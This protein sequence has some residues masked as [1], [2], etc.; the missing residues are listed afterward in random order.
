MSKLLISS[1]TGECTHFSIDREVTTVGRHSNNDLCLPHLSVSNSHALIFPGKDGLIL[2]DLQST[3]GTKVNG[4]PI[5]EQLLVHLDDI[6][7]G[8]YKISYSETTTAPADTTAPAQVSGTETSAKGVNLKDPQSTNGIKVHGEPKQEQVVV[9]LD[10]STIG[11]K[12]YSEPNTAPAHTSASAPVQ[13]SGSE[14]GAKNVNQLSPLVRKNW[15][16]I[17]KQFDYPVN[18]IG[19]KIE[20]GDTKTMLVWK[21]EKIDEDGRLSSFVSVT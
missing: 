12:S 10:D 2:R 20:L 16:A 8:T 14:T 13:V 15:V 6:T 1:D 18:A 4:E 9:Y 7:I 3:N 17:Q 19:L 21:R 5:Q 11:K